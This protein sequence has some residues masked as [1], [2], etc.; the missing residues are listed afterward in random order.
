MSTSDPKQP[1]RYQRN[2]GCLGLRIARVIIGFVVGPVLPC[3]LAQIFFGHASWGEALRGA[4]LLIFLA[5]LFSVV[6][7][8]PAYLVLQKS[9]YV[10]L[11]KSVVSGFLIGFA[12]FLW[13]VFPG[14]GVWDA[15]MALQSLGNCFAF[16]ALGAGIGL[17]FWG[18]AIWTP[19]RSFRHPSS[20]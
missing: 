12:A 18:L 17:A 9:G 6:L 1:S 5:W 3:L 2:G 7:A 11:S 16:G 13:I 15:N 20:D 10:S 8:V 4:W 19:R 14:S